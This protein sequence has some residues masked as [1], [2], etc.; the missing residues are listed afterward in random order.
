MSIYELNGR[1]G[2]AGTE[3]FLCTFEISSNPRELNT[4]QERSEVLT[5]IANYQQF[6]DYFILPYGY[7]NDLPQTIKKAVQENSQAPGMIEKKVF[8]IMGDG[9]F[10]YK[11][12][13]MQTDKGVVLVRDFGNDAEVQKWLDSWD[14]QTY[15]ERCAVDYEYMR[16]AFTMFKRNRGAR[17]GEKSF[18]AELEHKQLITSRLAIKKDSQTLSKPTHVAVT[19]NFEFNNL[20]SFLKM[21]FYPIIDWTDPF[22]DANSMMY[23][24]QYTFG[25]SYYSTPVLVGSLEW[26]RRSTATPLIFKYLSKNSVNVKFHLESPQEFWDDEEEKFKKRLEAQG[27]EYNPADFEKYRSDYIKGVTKVLE[28]EANVGKML[29]TRSVLNYQGVNVIERGWKLTPIEQK[30]KEFVESHLKIDNAAARSLSTALGMNTGISNVSQSGEVNGGSQQVY[31]AANFI[32]YSV[33]V[34]E[35]IICAPLNKAIKAN[36]P[37]TEYK[38]GFHR[39]TPQTLSNINPQDRPAAQ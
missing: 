23:S 15:L 19:D 11:E 6:G 33:D 22:R 17:L 38:I 12:K 31:A 13:F 21:K 34:P 16:G 18:I 36:F 24:S 8:M 4:F 35:R 27:K 26:L 37:N 29:H 1:S 5:N 30:I 32:N 3:D 2:I 14:Y 20:Q 39:Y 28:S 7:N 9:P 25:D 10:L